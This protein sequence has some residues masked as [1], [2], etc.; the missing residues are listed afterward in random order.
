[1]A[2][3][4]PLELQ[5]CEHIFVL[6]RVLGGVQFL[7]DAFQRF[8]RRVGLA[9]SGVGEDHVLIH[10][11]RTVG[12]G[13]A[14]R[15]VGKVLVQVRPHFPPAFEKSC[16]GGGQSFSFFKMDHQAHELPNGETDFHRSAAFRV[17][18]LARIVEHG[19]A[20]VER[21]SR[22]LGEMLLRDQVAPGMIGQRVRRDW[23]AIELADNAP[24]IAQG[25]YARGAIVIAM[26]TAV[27]AGFLILFGVQTIERLKSVENRWANYSEDAVRG[28]NLLQDLSMQ[29]GYGGF[30]HNFKNFILRRDFGDLGQLSKD[31]DGVYAL[32]SE[33]ESH[34]ITQDEMDALARIRMT[35]D[36][37]SSAVDRARHAFDSNLSSVEVDILVRID[38]GPAKD[39]FRL[40]ENSFRNRLQLAQSET[41]KALDSA[42]SIALLLLLVVPVVVML[43][44]L[45][46]MFL[47]RIV[48]GNA[49]LSEVR[50]E[51]SNLLRQAPDAILQVRDDGHIARVNDRAVALFGYPREE[52]LT[53]L[54]EDLIPHA[55]R[56][57]HVGIRDR[58][59]DG[60][61]DRPIGNGAD[62]VALT[63]DGRQ[64]PV[65]ISLSFS[66]TGGKRYATAIVRDVTERKRAEEVLQDAHDALER[67]V[68]ER[69]RELQRRT[70]Q[71]E[72][73][74]VER[75]RAQDQLVQSAK[76]ATIGEMASGITHE[77]NQPM[78]IM[79]MGVEAAQIK[80]Q[81]GQAD[82]GYL[83]EVLA[84]V[85]G[86]IVR[87]SDIITHM[88]A[89]SRLDTEGQVPFKPGHA[90]LD[91]CNLFSAQLL[92]DDIAFDVDVEP[93]L[94]LIMGHANRLE[95]VVL[96]LL[97]N[98]RDAVK[99]RQER[100]GPDVA[101]RIQVVVRADRDHNNL[102]ICV[103]DTGGGVPDDVLP[104]IFAPFVTTKESGRG[105]GLGLSISFGIVEGMGGAIEVVNV[106]KD[107]RVEGARFSMQFPLADE[108]TT[109]GAPKPLTSDAGAGLGA[110]LD[111]GAP[112]KGSVEKILVVD[113]EVGAANSLSDFLQELG[114]L[115][116]TAYN[117]EEALRLY[118]SDP[119]DVVIT[120]LRMPVMSGEELIRNL[121][122]ASQDVPIFVMTGHG[123]GE[124]S[125][126][127]PPGASGVWQKPLSLTEVARKLKA[128]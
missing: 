5:A 57:G 25:G 108:Q 89:Y 12:I 68:Q 85:E 49:S 126:D 70:E 11:Q 10:H 124:G 59:F 73:E 62:L 56:G 102:I 92:G 17:L 40:L 50:D 18:F 122:V 43:G 109:A 61:A 96:N 77:L 125:G 1:M 39:A 27:V 64:I 94:P 8:A 48:D 9:F 21:R 2:Q 51:L 29:M 52:F 120:D 95:Q 63:K 7:H 69:T 20:N 121:R 22:A 4:A 112:Q 46:V 99:T 114:Y 103:E 111:Q 75:K 71:L 30:I 117:G 23:G 42:S 83:S 127:M 90:V 106:T 93:D 79:R 116:Y 35:F 65:E 58:A 82:L 123:A 14:L 44:V 34:V 24:K 37:Y 45:L 101:G 66:A 74:M 88:R 28:S 33:L 41:Q 84:K 54:V 107:G 128:L 55:A 72:Q 31:R 3:F 76:M 19:H 6:R 13:V 15:Q 100:E 67:R 78:N 16:L 38:D 53:L 104:H 98:A 119:S 118:E 81:R 80:V 113:D 105:T 60:M 87:M 47:K 91:G 115:V 32:L 86:Q 36:R 97:S 26:V 110:A